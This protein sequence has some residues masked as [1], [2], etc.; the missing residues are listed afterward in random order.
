M[1]CP[2]GIVHAKNPNKLDGTNFNRGQEKMKLYLTTISLARLL[3]EEPLTHGE[4]IDQGV[5]LAL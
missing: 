2:A 4:D 5:L 1:T 3:T